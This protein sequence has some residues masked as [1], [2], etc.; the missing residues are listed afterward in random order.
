ME[1]IQYRSII[2]FLTSE[3]VEP[4]HIFDRLIS[5]YGDDAPSRATVFRWEREFRLGQKLL[6]DNEPPGGPRIAISDEL[7]DKV[8]AMIMSDRRF[9]V[10]DIACEL[11]MSI[12]SVFTILHDYVG[13]TKVCARG[14]PRMLTPVQKVTGVDVSRELLALHDRN[15]ADFAWHLV[16]GDE[17]WIHHWDPKTKQESMEWKHADSLPPKKFCTQDHSVHFLGRRGRYTN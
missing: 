17:T 5:V 2:Q 14:V 10:L 16:T 12:G 4:Q 15:P 3:K 8:E 6:E 1:K 13:M 11:Q 9:E 7:C